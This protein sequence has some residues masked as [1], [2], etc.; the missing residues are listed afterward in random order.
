M[1]LERLNNSQYDNDSFGENTFHD[2]FIKQMPCTLRNKLEEYLYQ[3]PQIIDYQIIE[4]F[5]RN[6]CAK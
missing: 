5:E 4:Y 2:Q 6:M 3:P 1:K